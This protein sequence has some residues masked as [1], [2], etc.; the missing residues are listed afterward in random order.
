MFMYELSYKACGIFMGIIS[1]CE[2]MG[3][4]LYIDLLGVHWDY[5]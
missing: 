4:H 1:V 2:I 3:I 5:K